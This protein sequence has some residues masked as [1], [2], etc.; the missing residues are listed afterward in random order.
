MTTYGRYLF[1]PKLSTRL[2]RKKK[3]TT[4]VPDPL[5]IRKDIRKPVGAIICFSY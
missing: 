5:E 2:L 4:K 1:L 3:R